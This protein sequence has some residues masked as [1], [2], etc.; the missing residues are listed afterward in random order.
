[1]VRRSTGGYVTPR[2]LTRYEYNNTMR[3]LLGIEMIT[4]KICR[5]IRREWM[6]T[7]QWRLHEYSNC[8][9]R[10]TT[11][12]PKRDLPPPSF[13]VIPSSRFITR[14]SSSK[15]SF[16]QPVAAP[17]DK[18][19]GGTVV[20]YSL[21]DPKRKSANKKNAMVLLCLDQ[22]PLPNV[23]VKIEA[24]AIGA[25]RN[26]RCQDARRNWAQDGCQGRTK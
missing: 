4:A 25:N 3:D 23:S 18:A 22:L 10:N 11:R 5:Q 8:N 2:R 16:R 13:K 19:L 6:A 14:H 20:G 21:K 7:E 12:Q 1:M 26:T 9:W 24:S 17:F 15:D